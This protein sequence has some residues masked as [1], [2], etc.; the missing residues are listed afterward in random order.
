[1]VLGKPKMRRVRR[2]SNYGWADDHVWRAE[3]N[4]AVVHAVCPVWAYCTVRELARRGW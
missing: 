3:L 1:M 2:R 4:G